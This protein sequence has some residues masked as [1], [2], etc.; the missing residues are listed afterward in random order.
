[1]ASDAQK[2]FHGIAARLD[3]MPISGFHMKIM[4]LLAG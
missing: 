1:M 2:S 3:R 4:W